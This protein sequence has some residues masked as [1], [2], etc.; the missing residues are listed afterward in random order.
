[1]HDAHSTMTPAPWSFDKDTPMFS[2][3]NVR[4]YDERVIMRRGRLFPQL[5]RDA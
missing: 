3:L 4:Q 1:M 5:L 2:V